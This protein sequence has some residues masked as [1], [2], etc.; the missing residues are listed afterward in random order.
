[1][2]H[3]SLWQIFPS[4]QRSGVGLLISNSTDFTSI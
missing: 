3:A 1:M 2:L 4:G